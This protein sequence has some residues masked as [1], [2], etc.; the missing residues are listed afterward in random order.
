MRHKYIPENAKAQANRL[1]DLTDSPQEWYLGIDT[2]QHEVLNQFYD[3]VMNSV[4]CL[5]MDEG[6]LLVVSTQMGLG[7]TSLWKDDKKLYTLEF[8]YEIRMFFNLTSELD[9]EGDWGAAVE[10]VA[11]QIVDWYK[12]GIVK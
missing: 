6:Y 4:S 12:A 11:R 9:I 7:T 2:S 10:N 8:E 1:M 5:L 3:D